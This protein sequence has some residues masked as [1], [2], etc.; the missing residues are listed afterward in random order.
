MK[1]GTISVMEENWDYLIILDACRYDYFRDMYQNHFS[2]KLESKLS[3]GSCTPEWCKKSFPKRYRHVI[4]VSGNPYI[5]SKTKVGAFDARKHF[6]RIIDVWDFG[7]SSELG[8]V[9]PEKI[10]GTTLRF[11][12]KFPEKRFIVHYLQ[13]H[14]PYISSKFR[15]KGYP[16]PNIKGKQVLQGI[17][18]SLGSG[19]IERFI[20]AISRAAVYARVRSALIADMTAKFGLV[21]NSWKLREILKLPPT[22]PLDTIRRV[23]GTEGLREAYKEN[24]RIV[25]SSVAELCNKLLHREPSRNIVI[26]SDHGEALGEKG[27]YSHFLNSKNPILLN[28]PWFKVTGV[29]TKY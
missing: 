22:S 17:Q 29:R 2:G 23:Y 16:T 11:V 9:L 26:T 1:T 13:P 7:W 25:L 12:K 14:P 8:T 4:Y 3:P 21:E 19:T 15:T 6:C 24:L 18:G 5:N 20:N 10:N 28:V 27:I